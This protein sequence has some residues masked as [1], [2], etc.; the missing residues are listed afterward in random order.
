VQD[1]GIGIL[2]GPDDCIFTVVGGDAGSG[3]GIA[4]AIG[5]FRN[6]SGQQFCVLKL[7]SEDGLADRA[8]IQLVAGVRA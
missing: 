3:S 2:R 4:E 5:G 1:S 6:G 7:K 8:K